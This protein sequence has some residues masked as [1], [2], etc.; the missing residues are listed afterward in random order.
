VRKRETEADLRRRLE[1]KRL[2]DEARRAADAKAQEEVRLKREQDVERQR[3]EQQAKDEEAKKRK[4]EMEIEAKRAA[5]ERLMR[6]GA[7]TAIEKA[8]RWVCVCCRRTGDWRGRAWL[9]LRR[10][11]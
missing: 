9:T 7:A 2:A 6:A 5:A 10:W 11:R 8:A 4:K 1:E 3:L